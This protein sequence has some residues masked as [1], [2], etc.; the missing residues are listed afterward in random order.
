MP[1]RQPERSIVAIVRVPPRGPPT[2]VLGTGF[3]VGREKLYLITAKH[4][5]DDVPLD[6]ADRPAIIWKLPGGQPRLIPLPLVRQHLDLDIAIAELPHIAE[7]L[8]LALV[9]QEIALDWQVLCYEFSHSSVTRAPDGTR[10]LQLQ[11]YSHMGNVVRCFDDE[12]AHGQRFMAI[13]TSFP[14]LQGASG[15]PVLRSPDLAVVGMLLANREKHLLPAQVV[16]V[17]EADGV[18]EEVRYFLPFGYGYAAT[19]IGLVLVGAGI[20]FAAVAAE[21]DSTGDTPPAS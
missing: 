7:A 6:G 16:R 11:P 21:E 8:P 5:F 14:A 2:E 12:D 17:E 1:L 4:I 15:A 18:V 19:M 9:C 3:I 13:E 10:L 20:E